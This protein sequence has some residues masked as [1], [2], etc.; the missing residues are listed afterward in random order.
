MSSKFVV[1][2][3]SIISWSKWG[4]I[5]SCLW[6]L[7]SWPPLFCLVLETV[8]LPVSSFKYCFI[9][10]CITWS[11]FFLLAI[12][13]D[14][15]SWYS[16]LLIFSSTWIFSSVTFILLVCSNINLLGIISFAISDFVSSVNSFIGLTWV[17]IRDASSVSLSDFNSV[18]F[19]DFSITWP[20][21]LR[22]NFSISPL[23]HKGI[24]FPSEI[25]F[26]SYLL[27]KFP[28]DFKSGVWKYYDEKGV[29]L[30]K[31]KYQKG[32]LLK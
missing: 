22:I 29:L 25:N 23:S 27:N 3:S 28:Y 1:I 31:E 30:K 8:F 16:V 15:K 21:V 6:K 19:L 17:L 14:S 9:S 20:N 12:H 26:N 7:P 32:R 11:G 18:E 24:A 10:S 5:V 13:L 4:I 2:L